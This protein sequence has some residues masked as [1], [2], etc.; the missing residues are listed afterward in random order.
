MGEA[1]APYEVACLWTPGPLPNQGLWAW[2]WLWVR[3]GPGPLAEQCVLATSLSV[4]PPAS[5]PCRSVPPVLSME[6]A[7]F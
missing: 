6:K 1:H 7:L 2:V 4:A 3:M 5:T